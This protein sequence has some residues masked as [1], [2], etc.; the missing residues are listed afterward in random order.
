MQPLKRILCIVCLAIFATN[1]FAQP[2]GFKNHI[3]NG[4]NPKTAGGVTTFHV[5]SGDC[6]SIDYGD[7][8][9]ESDCYNGNLRSHI[10]HNTHARLGESYLY[11]FEIRVPDGFNYAGG[12]NLRSLLEVIELGRVRGIKNHLYTFHLDARRGLTF[13]DIVCI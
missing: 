3:F 4:K 6:S 12:P 1:V 13:G 8:R 2:S 11:S 10:K 9:G 7:G 5:Q